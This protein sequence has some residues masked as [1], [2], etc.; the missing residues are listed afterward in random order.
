[1]LRWDRAG[2]L[3]PIAL[4]DPR[5]AELLAPMAPERMLRSWHLVAPDGSVASAGAAAAP[6]LRLLPGGSPLAALA[7]RA[8]GAVDWAYGKVAGNRSRLGPLVTSG[9]KARADRVIASR[10]RAPGRERRREI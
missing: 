6:L 2:T 8:P 4:Q 10:D 7:D 1:M 5:A 9:A 3:R